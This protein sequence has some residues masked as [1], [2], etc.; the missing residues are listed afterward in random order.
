MIPID[1]VT[2]IYGIILTPFYGDLINIP[3]FTIIDVVSVTK[4]DSVVIPIATKCGRY[5][6]VR[7]EGDIIFCLISPSVTLCF[8][9]IEQKRDKRKNFT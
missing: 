2:T 5:F 4:S 7:S 8:R 1:V 9:A 3:I 6:F